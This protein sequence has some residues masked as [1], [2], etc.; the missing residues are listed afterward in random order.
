MITPVALPSS[1]LADKYWS[2]L[3]ISGFTYFT[4]FFRKFAI[5]TTILTTTKQLEFAW[6]QI[7]AGN[8]RKTDI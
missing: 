7:F 1:S 6:R 5:L 2:G 3:S 4:Q 8:E